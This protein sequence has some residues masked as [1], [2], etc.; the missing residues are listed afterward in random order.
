MKI[1]LALN[2]I[3]TTLQILSPFPLCDLGVKIPT[4]IGGLGKT[5][6]STKPHVNP[7]GIGP[8]KFLTLF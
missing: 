8:S 5:F 7:Q 6:D 1:S 4:S 3:S 2:S